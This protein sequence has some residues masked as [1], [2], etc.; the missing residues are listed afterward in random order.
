MSCPQLCLVRSPQSCSTP[1]QSSRLGWSIAAQM[2]SSKAPIEASMIMLLLVAWQQK[3]QLRQQKQHGT[4]AAS[5]CPSLMAPA[6]P[7]HGSPW[8]AQVSQHNG[9]ICQHC[10]GRGIQRPLSRP[11]PNHPHQRP[12][13]RWAPSIDQ[14]LTATLGGGGGAHT[15]PLLQR[16]GS[17]CD[18]QRDACPSSPFNMSVHRYILHAVHPAARTAGKS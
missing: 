7:H 5:R 11:H 4:F 1:S 9:C 8:I 3:Q 16:P 17:P 2:P 13:F 12:C 14:P 10:S 6:V 15:T 18:C